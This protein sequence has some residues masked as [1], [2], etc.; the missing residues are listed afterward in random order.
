MNLP[1]HI[2]GGW[3]VSQNLVKFLK[4]KSKKEH[5]KL[6]ILGTIAG[7]IPDWDYI[8]YAVRSGALKYEGDFRHHTWITHTFPFYWVIAIL[9]FLIGI[10]RNNKSLQKEG[11]IFAAGTTTHLLQDAVGSGDGIMFLYPFSKRMFGIFLSGLHGKEW[12]RNYVKS[13]IYIVELLLIFFAVI[14]FLYDLIRR[15]V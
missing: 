6:L 15:K 10:F 9:V 8:L 11:A 12:Y 13:P 1:G 3:L 7:T 4:P 14:T 2:A 5:R